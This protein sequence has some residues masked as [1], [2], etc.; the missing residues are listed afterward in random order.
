MEF[1]LKVDSVIFEM[2]Q[3]V[4]RSMHLSRVL[5]VMGF[6]GWPVNAFRKCTRIEKI[7]VIAF[8]A[9]AVGRAPEVCQVDIAQ[10]FNMK[11]KI[12]EIRS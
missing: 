2:V 11:N 5:I 3:T 10:I 12:I 6:T 9:E 1:F 8:M 7:A 4:K